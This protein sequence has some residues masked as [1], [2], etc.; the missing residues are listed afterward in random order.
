[1]PVNIHGKEYITVAERVQAFHSETQDKVVS[2]TTEF[3]PNGGLVVCQ[4]TVK[5][6]DQVFQGTSAAN[7]AKAIEKTSPYEV[8]ETS[9]V[10][11]ALGFAGF[12]IV[13][14]IASAD[15]M[16]KALTEEKKPSV[17]RTDSFSSQ[18]RN[19][20]GNITSRQLGLVNIL[21]S[22]S[23]ADREKIHQAYEVTTLR[24]LTSGQASKLIDQLNKKI[25]T[26]SATHSE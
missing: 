9:A 4:A 12:G 10:G 7:P 3:L 24:D 8:A 19:S 18:Q 22:E 16:I 1:M 13:E 11:R 25:E 5:I 15:E 20:N 2:I 26:L 21:I 14:G 23:G 17:D 6:G